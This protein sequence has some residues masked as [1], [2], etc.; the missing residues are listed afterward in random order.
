MIFTFCYISLLYILFYIILFQPSLNEVVESVQYS[1]KSC[2]EEG[3]GDFNSCFSC[4]VVLLLFFFF[5]RKAH[6]KPMSVKTQMRTLTSASRMRVPLGV[7]QCV[8]YGDRQ[9]ATWGPLVKQRFAPSLLFCLTSIIFKTNMI[10]TLFKIF[11][12]SLILKHMLVFW[13]LDANSLQCHNRKKLL[14]TKILII[15]KIRTFKYCNKMV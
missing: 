1:W 11:K 6:E 13:Q 4:L 8:L 15:K 7:L 9:C 3:G 10:K 12:C 2:Y 14:R 5:S